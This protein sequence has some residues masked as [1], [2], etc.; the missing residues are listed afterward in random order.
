MW[1]IFNLQRKKAELG[2]NHDG[3]CACGF[4]IITI[5]VHS[6]PLLWLDCPPS[7]WCWL[8]PHL[9]LS[10]N[11]P[12]EP[13]H[14]LCVTHI[15]AKDI[16]WTLG[17]SWSDTP[18]TGCHDKTSLITMCPTVQN[19]SWSLHPFLN[20]W[21]GNYIPCTLFPMF[22]MSLG[23]YDFCMLCPLITI[24]LDHNIPWSQCPLDTMIRIFGTKHPLNGLI[25]FLGNKMYPSEFGKFFP[26]LSQPWIW[27][28]TTNRTSPIHGLVGCV[29]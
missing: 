7:V 24:D 21:F 1:F 20:L 23:V 2:T 25:Q 14:I 13:T 9:L 17:H 22:G 27:S 15:G 26:N 29:A 28:V 4:T 19:I 18:N 16:I 12:F 10:L 3:E 5:P 8:L 11:P 6:S